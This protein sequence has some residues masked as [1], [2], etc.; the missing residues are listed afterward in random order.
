MPNKDII[1]DSHASANESMTRDFATRADL[2][3]S[4]DF[5]K[6]SDPGVITD[7][8]AIQVDMAGELDTT[9][10]YN[11]FE[12]TKTRTINSNYIFITFVEMHGWNI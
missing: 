5:H 2:S 11:V 4:L 9:S 6:T 8:A 12:N 1:F 3:A 10:K 7:F